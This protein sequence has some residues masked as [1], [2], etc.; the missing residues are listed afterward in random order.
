MDADP[1][2]TTPSMPA[3]PDDAPWK[4]RA[5]ADLRARLI[6]AGMTPAEYRAHIARAE[7]IAGV[8][9]RVAD[10][11]TRFLSRSKATVA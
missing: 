8:Y 2:M 3:R 9:A 7:A 4:Q 5:L 11:L 1:K 6:P 10:V